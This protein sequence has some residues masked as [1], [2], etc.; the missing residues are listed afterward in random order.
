MLLLTMKELNFDEIKLYLKKVDDGKAI[1]I[2]SLSN[3]RSGRDLF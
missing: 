3:R 1:C 2:W